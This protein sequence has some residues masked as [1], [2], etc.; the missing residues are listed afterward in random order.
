[1][2]ASAARAL[3]LTAALAVLPA[4][5]P[6]LAAADP[7]YTDVTESHLPADDL[8]GLSMDAALADFD[9]DGDLDILIANEFRPNILLINDGTGRF[10]NES[11]A[12]LPRDSHD[13]EDIAVADFDGDGDLD[14]VIVSEDDKTNELYLNRGD[15][16]FEAAGARLPV[17]GV[18]NGVAAGDVDG[19]GDSDL[20][21]GNNGQN[22]LLL[23]DGAGTFTDATGRLPQIADTT[24]DV[25]LG[26]A[27]GDG[28]LDLIAGNE[29]DN[30]LMLNDGT[31]RFTDAPLPLRETIEETREAD[32][33]DVDG[34]GDLDLLFANVRFFTEEGDPANRLLLNDGAGVFA[35]V[36]LERL[37]ADTNTEAS[38]EGDLIDL[39]R[40]GDLDIITGNVTAVRE[41]GRALFRVWSNDG[42]GRF[43]EASAAILP[44]TARGNGFDVASGD[45]NGDG[46][47]DL[48]LAN[49]YGADR[50]LLGVAED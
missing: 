14:A 33:G 35:D 18:S 30:R 23:N 45:V 21:I 32:W 20:V 34:D 48:Y 19:D 4:L 43:T 37:P 7:I 40:D 47:L 6:A 39:D 9:A 24:Q 31:G 10:T 41:A 11:E 28:D 38:A 44:D 22:A 17:D 13:S 1:M 25:A 27:D 50:L 3:A 2:T 12:R 42:A 16:T 49:R 15:G 36:S 8:T 46:L 5:L 26:D 29:D